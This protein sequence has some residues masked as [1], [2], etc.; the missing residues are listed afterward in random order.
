MESRSHFWARQALIPVC[1]ALALAVLLSSPI[2]A[3]AAPILRTG[4]QGDSVRQLQQSL[5]ALGYDPGPQD[6]DFGPRTLAAV[7]KLQ[8]SSGLV[9]DGICGPL[10]WSAI[11]R[12]SQAGVTSRSAGPLRGRLVVIDPGHG[13]NEPGALSTWGDREKDFTL[14]IASKV[15]QYLEAQGATVQLTRYGDYTPGGDWGRTVDELAARASLAN[16]NDADIFVSI[17]NNSYPKDPNTSGVMAFY[18]SGSAESMSLAKSLATGVNATTGLR[19]IDVQVGPYYVL[20]HTVMPAALVEVGFMTNWHDVN[21]LRQNSFI[22]D[23]ARGI[24]AGIV[25]YLGR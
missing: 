11:D 16:S 9:P 12:L 4:S 18:R 5:S 20:S 13:G 22:D 24:A 17:H 10:T 14:R 21:L 23:A 19:F 2:R 6:G 15:R 3:A 7:V 25:D 1:A 8:N